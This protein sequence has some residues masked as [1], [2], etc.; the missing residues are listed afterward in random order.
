MKFLK[1]PL[2]AAALGSSAI[3]LSVAAPSETQATS[4]VPI[5]VWALRDVVNAVDLSPDGKHLL[6]HI[7]MSREGEYLLQIFKTDDL[8]TP[9]RTLNADPM[10][11]IGAQWVSDNIIVGRAWEQVR[12][13]VR[14][15]EDATYNY[16]T[17]FYDLEANKF[18]Q[19]SD[20]LVVVNDLPNDPDRV[21]V[22]APS[23][24]AGG[25]GVDPFAAFRPRSF[26]KLNL[27]NGTKNLVIRGST[28]YGGI[29]FDNDGNPRYATGFDTDNTVKTYYRKPG[30]GSWTQFGDVYDQ[31]DHDNLYRFLGGIEGLA[32]FSAEDPNVGYMVEARNGADKASLWEFNFETG[33]YGEELFASE[34]S[35]VMGVGVN[36][37]PGDDR[38]AFAMYPGAKYERHWFD[39][40]EKALYEALEAQIPYAHQVSISSRSYDGRTMIVRNSGPKDPGSFWLVKDGQLAK[41]GSRNPLL[42]QAVLADVEYIRYPS[43]DGKLMIPAYVTVPKGEGPFPLIVQHNGGPHV[44]AVQGYSEF[45]QMLASAGY[46]VLYPQNRI[47]TGW[48][49]EHFD[50]GYGE[51]GLAMQDDK[52]D[53]VKYLIDQGLVD[54]DR[55]AFWGWSYGGY[56]ALVSLSREEQ[57]YQCA[58]AINAVS[59]PAKTFRMG[60]GR[61]G[62]GYPKAILDWA[63]RRGTIGINPIEEVAKVNIPLLMVHGD[64]DSRVLYYHFEDYKKAFEAAGKTGDFVTLVGA[65]HFGN[66]QM[67]NHQQQLYTK[68][69]DYLANDCGPGGL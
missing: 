23:A 36:S 38:L 20:N 60:A 30:D 25:Y 17:Y 8:S 65:D 29:Q 59:D 31:D 44:N 66:T 13:R 14:R 10:E 49:K 11:I 18:S 47:S 26:Y 50:A 2:M 1:V 28:K 52:D 68:M 43:R 21:L 19:V 64:V 58:I 54:P 33:E 22:A 35:D 63:E 56:A 45:G 7:N 48:G 5:E 37:I 69:F 39:E 32:G 15:Q 67:Y 55:V 41:L 34:E 27:R 57:L 46:M 42:N 3:G 40:D 51:H 61:A 24:N 12:E 6:V 4:S 53:G 16:A 62:G 9:Y